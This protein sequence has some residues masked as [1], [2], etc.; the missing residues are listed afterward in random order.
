MV[1]IRV[2]VAGRIR[3]VAGSSRATAA[4]APR[5]A[6][7]TAGLVAGR[8]TTEMI[9]RP[10]DPTARVMRPASNHAAIRRRSIDRLH[11][12]LARER[13]IVVSTLPQ[14]A[15]GTIGAP[16][17]RWLACRRRLEEPWSLILAD[18]AVSWG[19]ALGARLRRWTTREIDR[20]RPSDRNESAPVFAIET[21]G[22]SGDEAISRHHALLPPTRTHRTDHPIV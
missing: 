4:T 14:A 11:P 3:G 21:I 1:L 5:L 15:R 13:L 2:F 8:P 9:D 18:L 17:H 7:A 22:A 12:N 19:F 10:F 20:R 6:A 16:G